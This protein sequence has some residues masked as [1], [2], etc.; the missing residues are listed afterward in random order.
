[1]KEI[2]LDILIKD[3]LGLTDKEDFILP[4]GKNAKIRDI[5][6]NHCGMFQTTDGEK[7]I[8]S[9]DLGIKIRNAHKKI[10]LEDAEL[11]FLRTG[12]LSQP[13]FVAMVMAQTFKIL[14]KAKVIEI[15]ETNKN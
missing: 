2:E 5:L 7:S 1:M 12:P 3:D 14:D 4:N 9:Y 15:K 8:Q 10:I 13:K 6:I 11:N